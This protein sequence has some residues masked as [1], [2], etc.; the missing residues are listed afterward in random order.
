M[1]HRLIRRKSSREPGASHADD[2]AIGRREQSERVVDR[3]VQR[4]KYVGP[5]QHDVHE[6]RDDDDCEQARDQGPN[7]FGLHDSSMA[8]RNISSKRTATVT[9]A[10]SRAVTATASPAD[11]TPSCDTLR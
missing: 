5:V 11:T 9:A 4:R 6:G 2:E 1:L 8:P 7:R 10:L 3:L